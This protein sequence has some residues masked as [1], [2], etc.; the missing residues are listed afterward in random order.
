MLRRMRYETYPYDTDLTD[1][2]YA[3]IEPFLPRPK[4]TG[5]PSADLRE[6][7]NGILYLVRT[8]CQWRLLPQDFPPW[9]T[10]HTWY[11]RWR[12]DGTW[13]GI[14]EALRRQVRWP[15][16][17]RSF[18][19]RLLPSTASR[20]RPPTVGGRPATTAAR[21]SRGRKRHIWVDTMGLLL[22]VVGD[23]RQRPGRPRPLATALRSD[24]ERDDLP[25]LDVVL[26][27]Q[28]VSS[29]MPARGGVRASP[30]FRLAVVVAG[31][32]AP[33]GWRATCRERWV[34]ERTFAWLGR[35][36]R[37][38]QGLRTAAGNRAKP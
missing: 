32:R 20:S 11:R 8:G 28:P 29:R 6:V 4:R 9:S 36:R 17:P 23:G 24:A 27:R 10:V 13:D 19:A 14:K 35:S 37:L 3:L 21:R 34:V 33:E 30:P 22:A 5:R 1:N 16:R 15:G 31:R 2:Q 12:S 18:A 7:V 25:R 26:R 38:S